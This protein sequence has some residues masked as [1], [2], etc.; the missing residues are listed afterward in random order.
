MRETGFERLRRAWA[1]LA[2]VL[3]NTC[4]LLVVLNLV[5][6]VVFRVLDG[7]RSRPLRYARSP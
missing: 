3:L 1:S 6:F 5:L 7:R 4:L 2:L